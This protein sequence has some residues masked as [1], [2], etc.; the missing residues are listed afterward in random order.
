MA[1]HPMIYD[2]VTDQQR[3]VTQADVDRLVRIA[4]A[5]LR[6]AALLNTADR[7][8]PPADQAPPRG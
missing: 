1:D 3:L 6:A 2:P 7:P 8:D 4:G 5:A